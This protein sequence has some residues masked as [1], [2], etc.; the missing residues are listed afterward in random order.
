MARV[1]VEVLRSQNSGAPTSKR[2]RPRG[3]KRN[4]SVTVM[5]AKIF[6]GNISEFINLTGSINQ[7]LQLILRSDDDHL[8]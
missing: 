5:G 1:I 3:P 8:L 2:L 4:V 6:M 7:H